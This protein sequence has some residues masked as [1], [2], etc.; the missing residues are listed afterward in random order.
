MIADHQGIALEV[1]NTLNVQLAVEPE[2]SES[3][4][5]DLDQTGYGGSIPGPAIGG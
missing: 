2:R 1:E 3:T 4:P 5:I